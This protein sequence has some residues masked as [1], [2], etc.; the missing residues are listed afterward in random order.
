MS[1]SVCLVTVPDIET[2]RKISSQVVEHS[3]AACVN[4]VPKVIS[5]YRWKGQIEEENELLL[6]IKTCS[7]KVSHLEKLVLEIH[8]YDTPEFIVLAASQVNSAYQNWIK[9]SVT[10]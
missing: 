1:I 10:K 9:E 6:I 4:I 8:P 2:A 7:S 5:T 3:H